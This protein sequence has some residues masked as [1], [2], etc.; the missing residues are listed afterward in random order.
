MSVRSRSRITNS[1][2]RCTITFRLSPI[3]RVAPL[4]RSLGPFCA[5]LSLSSQHELPL[6]FVLASGQLR[7]AL[8]WGRISWVKGVLWSYTAA[9][10]L[11][12]FRGRKA[13]CEDVQGFLIFVRIRVMI[14]NSDLEFDF[15]IVATVIYFD[16]SRWR[17]K[18][19]VGNNSWRMYFWI[20]QG[21]ASFIFVLIGIVSEV[22]VTFKYLKY[23]HL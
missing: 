5:P 4:P 1:Q 13:Q 20:L 19:E 6:S 15:S 17:W 7:Y 18:F 22:L 12:F 9:G 16:S 2:W 3:K 14:K 23:H 10:F 8:C 21:Y 11:I